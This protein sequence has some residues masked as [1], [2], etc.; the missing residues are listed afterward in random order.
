MNISTTIAI[1]DEV[2]FTLKSHGETDE[3]TWVCR[4]L[5]DKKLHSIALM[6][7]TKI[8]YNIAKQKIKNDAD[9]IESHKGP[10]TLG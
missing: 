7:L 6:E 2:I 3:L 5:S 10:I 1:D 4:S 9:R 8:A